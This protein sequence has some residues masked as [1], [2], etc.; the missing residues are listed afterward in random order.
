MSSSLM[1]PAPRVEIPPSF[2][3]SSAAGVAGRMRAMILVWVSASAPRAPWR[4]RGGHVVE[5]RGDSR[6]VLLAAAPFRRRRAA[7]SRPRRTCP[8]AA[9]APARRLSRR[10]LRGT[11]SH[12]FPRVGG[13]HGGEDSRAFSSLIALTGGGGGC[14]KTRQDRRGGLGTCRSSCA[15]SPRALWPMSASPPA[16][17]ADSRAPARRRWGPAFAGCR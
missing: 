15:P 14:G 11:C 6:D 5:H 16:P 1:L 2:F 4:L 3:P 7:A 13:G 9:R 17:G 12:H 10:G 8:S